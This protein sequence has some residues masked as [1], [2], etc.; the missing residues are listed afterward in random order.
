MTKIMHLVAAC[1]LMLCSDMLHAQT[2]LQTTNPSCVIPADSGSV[3]FVMMKD[4]VLNIENSTTEDITLHIYGD[5][6][7]WFHTLPVGGF[8][9]ML[10]WENGRTVTQIDIPECSM[11]LWYDWKR[12]TFGH[13][14]TRYEGWND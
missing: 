3:T 6:E 7:E 4:T 1:Y 2:N 8:C 13:I 9:P 12:K 5:C 10:V 11:H 14:T